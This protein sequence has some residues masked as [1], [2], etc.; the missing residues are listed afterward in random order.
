MPYL[1]SLFYE[2]HTT[3]IPI[4]RSLIMEYPEDRNVSNVCDQFLLGPS[5]LVAP[6]YRP[7]V[8]SRAVYL[9]EGVWY[10][11]WTGEKLEGGKSVL[12]EAP[13]ER[14]PLYVKAGS[15][16]PEQELRQSMNESSEQPLRVRIR[17][18][19]GHDGI[20]RFS[21]YED[22]GR[23]YAFEAGRFTLRE[24]S[25]QQSLDGIR[26]ACDYASDG[27]P[28][29]EELILALSPVE[30]KPTKISSSGNVETDA[31]IYDEAKQTLQ[32]T[33]KAKHSFELQIR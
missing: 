14:I 6:I 3:G 26:V 29:G 5:L 20:H 21:Q 1:Y 17:V 28:C 24:W 22:D 7:G 23:T 12:A 27:W 2:A 11:Y 31:W 13:L 15:I 16:I 8:Q 25:V 30:S 32:V 33:I 9:P 19:S 4:V 18:G 10:D